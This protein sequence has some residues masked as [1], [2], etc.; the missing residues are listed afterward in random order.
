MT[1]RKKRALFGVGFL[2]LVALVGWLVAPSYIKWRINQKPGVNVASVQILGL[3]CVQLDS[4]TITREWVYGKVDHAKVCE[5][6]QTIDAE[7]GELT[8]LLDRRPTHG[9]GTSGSAKNFKV[10][11]RDLITQVVKGD[12]K[13]AVANIEGDLQKGF[14]APWA[15]VDHPKVGLTTVNVKVSPTGDQVSFEGGQAVLKERIFNLDVEVVL[16]SATTLRPREGSLT[17]DSVKSRLVTAEKVTATYESALTFS[18]D[19]I[20][21]RDDRLHKEAITLTNV[22]LG[23]FNPKEA[24]TTNQAIHANGVT[25]NVNVKEKHVWGSQTCQEWYKALPEELRIAPL[26]GL[27]FEGDFEFDLHLEPKVKLDWKLGCHNPKPAPAII[28]GLTSKFTYVAFKADGSEFTRETGPKSS[29]WVPLIDI[30]PTMVTALQ[31]TEDPAF[32]QHKG[33]IRQ[34]LEN[35]LADNVKMGKPFRGG[36]TLTM[37]LA[38][39]LWLRRSK[40]IGRKVQEAFLTIVL[41]SYLTKE[42]IVELYLNVV[43]FGP[44]LYGIGSAAKTLT[45]VEPSFLTLSDSLYLALRLPKPTKSGPFDDAR[46]AV[47]KKLIGSMAASGKI[48]EDVAEAEASVLEP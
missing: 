30:S 43:E 10:T 6:Q 48:T 25:L 4:V 23:P 29:S 21:F 5:D 12:V 27:T 8:V 40:T 35:A 13:A 46:K 1:Q 15:V 39:N 9:E 47:V 31:A 2:L 44:N 17:I 7:G 26:Q 18:A 11:T 22:S 16:L 41:E 42:Q 28:A 45:G 3:H 24:L 38:K 14:T 19:S 33:F 32:F 36:S 20:R 34:A 37:Q